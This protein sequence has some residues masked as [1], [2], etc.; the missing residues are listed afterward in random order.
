[1]KSKRF[2]FFSFTLVLTFLLSV[3]SC[4]W[5]DPDI[6]INPDTPTDVPMNL[7]L[8]NIQANMGYDIGGNDI[9]RPT[10]MWM[11]YFNGYARQ[12]LSQGRYA[13]TPSDVNNVWNSLYWGVLMDIKLLK[14]K[15]E[16]T[17]SVHF[18]GVGN[19][20]NALTLMTLTD[21]FGDIPWTEALQGGANLSPKLDS[22][23]SIYVVAIG[24]L[25]EAIVQLAATNEGIALSGD[26]IYGNNRT[27]WRNAAYAL[28]ARAILVQSKRNANAYSQVL[29]VLAE[30]G[31]TSTAD[32]MVLFYSEAQ[33]LPHPLFQ[34]VRD[35]GDIT[36]GETFVDILLLDEDP[37]IDLYISGDEVGG[38]IGGEDI[39]DIGQPGPYAAAEDAGTW[40]ITYAE[41]KFMEAE[42]LL[43]TNATAAYDAFLAGTM[44][45]LVQVGVDTTDI[46]DTD[47]Y[48]NL[49]AG[50]SAG[51]DIEKIMRQKYIALYNTGFFY[52]DWRRHGFPAELVMPINAALSQTPRRYPYG[53]S[54]ITY[55]ENVSPVEI[56]ERVWWDAN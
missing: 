13:Y 55:N 18:L 15:A 19:V 27:K 38:A 29:A 16:A 22:Q 45:S 54:E 10:N 6:N 9:V 30:G 4:E 47:F 8:P 25:D 24:M 43:P 23:E 52:N 36:M 48:A 42:A 39:D 37:R 20:L 2:K 17:N 11:Q 3:S 33:G 5:V 14:E 46:K 21:L 28:K 53:Q 7:I 32:N 35:R 50:G 41:Q 51:L 1:M 56:T 12:S 49:T 40:F 26:L 44:S 34:F 31:I